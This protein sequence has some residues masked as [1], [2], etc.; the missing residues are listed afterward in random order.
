MHKTPLNF[1]RGSLLKT[2]F[3]NGIKMCPTTNGKSFWDLKEIYVFY[4]KKLVLGHFIT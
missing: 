1:K 3:K 4:M 2:N